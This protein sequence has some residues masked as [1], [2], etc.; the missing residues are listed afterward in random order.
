MFIGF[1]SLM[2]SSHILILL[3][4]LFS[5]LVFRAFI[6]LNL[7]LNFRIS[8]NLMFLRGTWSHGWGGGGG[9][10]FFLLPGEGLHQ[11]W[12]EN[13]LDTIDLTYPGGGELNL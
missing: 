5:L 8:G 1:K 12:P 13:P 3:S 4:L 7:S 11:L 6:S 2:T 9:S 10:I